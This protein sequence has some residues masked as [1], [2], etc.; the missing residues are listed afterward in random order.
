MKGSDKWGQGGGPRIRVDVLLV[1]RVV[2]LVAVYFFV[3]SSSQNS[4]V[5]VGGVTTI[6]TT[7]VPCDDNAMPQA[8]QAVEQ[9]PT[10]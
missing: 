9:D 8:A 5:R 3:G 7:G 10:F 4:N 2:R 6:S 1:A